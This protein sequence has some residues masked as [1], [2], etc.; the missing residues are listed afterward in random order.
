MDAKTVKGY[1]KG[2]CNDIDEG[3]PLRRFDIR[4]FLA[5][6]AIPAALTLS[7]GTAGC[8]EPVD[9]EPDPIE[10]V[11]TDGF[12]DDGDGWIDCDD[13]DCDLDPSCAVALYMAPLPEDCDDGEDNDF[14]G[15]VDCDDEDCLE[16]IVCTVVPE[17]AAPM[18]EDD[19]D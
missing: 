17:Y 7:L 6:V 3:R 19:C 18:P 12:D 15:L 4:R 11:C 5:P 2:L 16:D 10:E 13:D 14:D 8:L 1:L 9:P